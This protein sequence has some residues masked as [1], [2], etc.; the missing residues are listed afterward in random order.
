VELKDVINTYS[1]LFTLGLD[2]ISWGYFK[3]VLN[4]VKCYSNIVNIANTC[5][6]LSYW[7]SHFIKLSSIIVPKLNKSSY[8]IPKAFY[9]I[10]LLNILEK[11]IKKVINKR[12]QVYTIT[13][14]F[15]HPSQLGNIK[16]H[17]AIDTGIFLTHLIQIG[18]I[19]DLYTS[20]LVF[21]IA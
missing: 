12:L 10:M 7:L 6:N 8:D 5:I 20:I 4:D 1:N 11:L 2:H 3:E 13:S 18:W 14:N 9:F 15:I 17:L 21:D 16:Q 19:K